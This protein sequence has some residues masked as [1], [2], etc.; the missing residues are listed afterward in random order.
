MHVNNKMELD[1]KKQLNVDIK[2]YTINANTNTFEHIEKRHGENGEHDRS[3]KNMDDVALMAYV[4]DNY[5][6]VEV[7]KNAKGELAITHAFT[8]KDGTGAPMMRFEKDINGKQYVV[9]AVVENKYK[10]LW[11][12]SEYKKEDTLC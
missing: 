2:G 5:D 6:R 3:M 1:A 11:V 9:V 12:V 10:K 7:L 8:A 4:L